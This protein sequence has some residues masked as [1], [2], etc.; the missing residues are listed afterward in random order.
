MKGKNFGLV[1]EGNRNYV[2]NLNEISRPCSQFFVPV[3]DLITRYPR[4]SLE[5]L[6]SC[7]VFL[8]FRDIIQGPP[9][10]HSEQQSHVLIM[11]DQRYDCIQLLPFESQE[12]SGVLGQGTW[13]D[14]HAITPFC[15]ERHDITPI[16]VK[17]IWHD[18]VS[19]PIIGVITPK[20]DL[21]K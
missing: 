12:G 18:G 5:V 3:D 2:K 15:C 6:T 10:V 7:L 20:T 8:Q 17:K 16:F 19:M 9:V 11:H 21:H 13:R 14:H 1:L 4:I